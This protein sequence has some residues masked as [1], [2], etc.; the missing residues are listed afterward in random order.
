MPAFE[1]TDVLEV[2]DQ[3]FDCKAWH[4]INLKSSVKGVS[5]EWAAWRPDPRAHNI[6]EIIV[7]AAYW[8]HIVRQRLLGVRAGVFPH[9]GTHWFVR[10]GRTSRAAWDAAWKEDVR[11]LKETH[12]ALRELIAE[13][14]PSE[15]ELRVSGTWTRRQTIIGIASHDLYHA[16]QIQLIKSLLRKKIRE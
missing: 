5:A 4:G 10:P 1:L 6:W 8:K 9:K 11:L 2:L 16:G 13:L 12:R 14:T 7:H 3:A 15:L